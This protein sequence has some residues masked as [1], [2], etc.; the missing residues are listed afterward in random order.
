MSANVES[1]AY[2]HNMVKFD[3]QPPWHGLGVSVQD[4]DCLFDV[5]KF[6]EKAGI[7]WDVFKEP[8]LTLSRAKAALKLG[9]QN[10]ENE[11]D[12]DADTDAYAVRRR[13]DGNIL[14]VVGPQYRPLQ[15]SE[16][17][18]WFEPWTENKLIAL[19]TAGSLCGGKKI[20]VL[21]QVVKDTIMDITGQDTIAKFVM[22]SNS[23]DGTAAVRVG[24]CG[25][26]I[27]CQ[28]TMYMAHHSSE[29]KLVR[30]RH[31]SQMERNMEAMRDVIDLVNNDFNS[32]AEQYKWLTTRHVN[33][34]DLQK[35]FR[36]LVQG[37]KT[38]KHHLMKSALAPRILLRR[39]SLGWKCLIKSYP[40]GVGGQPIIRSTNILIMNKVE[41]LILDCR[42]YGLVKVPPKIKRLLSWL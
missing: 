23:H 21:G 4:E 17:L 11:F 6:G 38:P 8:L 28:N 25:I 10:P 9:R 15:N 22:L 7:N 5:E 29:S 19:S 33:Q 36:V 26:R 40:L 16:A 20:W 30:I 42:I 39:L 2:I 12:L 3:S 31:S 13:T 32:S 1:M 18:K 14:G 34:K 41:M 37:E 27:V 35:Y 24:L